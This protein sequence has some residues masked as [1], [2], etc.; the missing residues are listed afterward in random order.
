MNVPE[1]LRYS[2]DHGWVRLESDSPGDLVRVGITDYAQDLIGEVEFVALPAPGTRLAAGELMA[3]IEARKATSE[4]Y[5]PLS[6]RVTEVNETLAEAPGVL[7]GDPYGDGWLCLVAP[8]DAAQLDGLM[9][10]A[11]Y[12]RFIGG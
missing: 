3:E 11:A 5:S 7:N 2:E 6:G 12:A 1:R 10:D 9:D 4:L 8:D